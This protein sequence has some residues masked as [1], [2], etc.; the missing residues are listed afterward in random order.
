MDP[1]KSNPHSHLTAKE[2]DSISFPT[3]I[4]HERGLLRGQVLDFGCGLGADVRIL[5][6]RGIDIVGYDK[7]YAPTYPQQQFDTIICIYVLNVLFPDEQAQVFRQISELLKPGGHAYF[8][9]RRDIRNEGF[10]M[11]K[12]HQQ[13]TYQC[14]VVLDY[15]SLLRNE[16]CEIYGLEKTQESAPKPA[17]CPFC[18][19]DTHREIIAET[20][21]AYAIFDGYPVSPGHVLVI[22]LVHE[23]DYFALPV[24]VRESMWFLANHVSEVLQERYSPDGFNVGINVGEAAGQ[25]VMHAHVH[26]IP[27]YAGDVAEPRGGVRGVVPAKQEYRDR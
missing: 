25:T 2:R 8:A 23:A 11:H 27:R 19:L 24:K 5:K 14:N 16:Y 6:K 7:F 1:L 4:L 12:I 3:R 9:V 22:P 26:V 10:R 17:P 18:N 21:H 20:P 15:P 13:Q